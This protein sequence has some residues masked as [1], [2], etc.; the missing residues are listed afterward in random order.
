M[1]ISLANTYA[2]MSS[3]LNFH[4]IV[5]LTLV[6]SKVNPVVESMSSV[7]PVPAALCLIS[8]QTPHCLS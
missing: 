6:T 2:W 7:L 3:L 5:T 4:C 1:P 8:S